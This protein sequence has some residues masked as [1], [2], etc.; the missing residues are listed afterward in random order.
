M[1]AERLRLAV[2]WRGESGRKGNALTGGAGWSVAKEGRRRGGSCLAEMGRCG[3]GCWANVLA[4][5]GGARLARRQGG[6]ATNWASGRE[7]GHG[8]K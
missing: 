8:P 1:G 4:G 3:D 2:D 6:P 5:L 7:K